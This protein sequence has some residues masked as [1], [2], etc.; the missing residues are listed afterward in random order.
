MRPFISLLPI[1][2]K[3]SETVCWGPLVI[4]CICLL[5]ALGRP[6]AAQERQLSVTV[7][8]A[9]TSTPLPA[10]LYLQSSAGRAY[11][12]STKHPADGT[13]VK[14]EKQSWINA[15]ST[16]YHTTVSAHAAITRLPPGKYQLVV[17]RGKEY[18]TETRDIEIVEA[19][20]DLRIALRRW[21]DA[22]ARGWYSGDTHIHRTIEELKNIIQAEDLNVVMPLTYWVTRS[23]TPPS[24][25]D[26]NLS[27]E[28]PA[29]LVTVD[30][31]HVIWP[32]NTEY[33][34]FS[35]GAK[36][37]TLGALFVLGH[38]QPL[39]LG[40]PNW[41]PI[42]KS[43][44]SEK[45]VLYDLD[46]LDWPFAML[47]PTLAPG[48]LYE[49][50]NNHMWRT[51]FAFEKWNSVA[52][53]YM[54]P[55]SGSGVGGERQW[56]DY[57]QAMYYS[58]LNC[59]LKL[60]PT[61]GTANGV[62][63][64]PAGYG[65]VYVHLDGAFSYE[66][67]IEGLRRGRSFV[68]T[69]PMLV[70][71]ADSKDAGHVFRFSGTESQTYSVPIDIEVVSQSPILYG[72]LLVNGEPITLLRPANKLTENGS[73]LSTLKTMAKIDRS[74][75]FAIRMW[76]EPGAGRIRFAH[77]A[78]WY[79]EVNKQPVRIRREE[80][81]YLVDRMQQ[82]IQRSTGTLD[83]AALDEYRKA[84]QFYAERPVL[85]DSSVVRDTSR[86]L[87][88]DQT[89]WLDNMIIHHQFTPHEV[90][91]ATGLPTE[92]ADRQ[93]ELRR[94]QLGQKNADQQ[95]GIMVVPYPGGRHPRRGFLDGAVDPQ[96]ETKVSVFT[97]W[98][99]GGYAVVDV[100]EAIF[101]NLG[102]TYLAHRHVRTIWE[103]QNI[104]LPRLEW[105]TVGSG[106]RGQRT[107]PNGI[108]FGSKVDPAGTHVR[109]E[110][111]LTNGTDKK[112]TNQRSQVC[113]MLKGM[114]GF[115]SQSTPTTIINGPI[116]AMR[117]ERLPRWIVTGWTAHH[118]SWN[119]PP[120]PCIHSDPI[121]PDCQPGETVRVVGG[122]WFYEG[123]Q[124]GPDISSQFL[125]AL[126]TWARDK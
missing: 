81:D 124:I 43:T 121:F 4:G 46:K 64:V 82:E 66:K 104:T 40:V 126:Q 44:Q 16:E 24:S 80:R 79:V 106:L 58:L 42:I 1:R 88:D 119:N 87:G 37:H 55:P 17:Q 35:I 105:E 74:G 25:G 77:T 7:V 57:T 115:N 114:P 19:D 49:L 9:A 32:R 122:L 70:A 91:L 116:I 41:E 48:A 39:N 86:S 75:W 28:I 36:R 98:R 11:F 18:H 52:P 47:L 22:A 90:R 59:G 31:R 69:G 95:P 125:S 34:I 27:G 56:I 8:D 78:P 108:R 85:D 23:H 100:P 51:E 67:W 99:D 112:L 20:V 92:E 73:Y 61:A 71:T 103:T 117:H 6:S 93:I 72:E 113:V 50:A 5:L 53:S 12:F 54:Q 2:S 110:M 21:F 3:S 26:K 14:Y 45:N 76:E 94:G 38:T 89:A 111:W 33:E 123:D 60:P 15:K 84:L 65:R 83:A 30:E 10:R 118:R 107:L 101:S 109:M 68:T 120:V 29:G 102:L 62:H 96:R 63:P 97:P 13:A